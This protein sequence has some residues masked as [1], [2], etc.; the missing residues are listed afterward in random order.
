MT[1]EDNHPK[2][3]Y[4]YAYDSLP[5]LPMAGPL[6]PVEGF[7]ARPA[8]ISLA[9]VPALKILVNTIMLGVR[10]TSADAEFVPGVLRELGAA[11]QSLRASNR[12]TDHAPVW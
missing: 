11:A 8:F 3:G 9:S 10:N 7:A 5:P 12:T 4:T 1:P 2:A 6:P